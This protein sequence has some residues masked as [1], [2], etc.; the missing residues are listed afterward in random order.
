MAATSGPGS[1]PPL[2]QIA[3]AN[4]EALRIAWVWEA[5]DNHRYARRRAK[6]PDGFKATPLMVGG[7]LIVRTAFSAVAALDPLTGETLWTFDPGT[8]D[9]PRPPMFGFSTRGLAYHQ[10]EDGGRILLLTSD[11]WL[12]A[13]SPQTG[14]PLTD[15]GKAGRVDLT[16]GLR[17]P[18]LRSASSWNYAPA[19]CGDVVVV[20]NQTSDT[21]HISSFRRGGREWQDNVP[22]G[23]VRGFDV[24][25]GRRL[26]A[27]KT[28]P[29]AGEFGN[30][31]WGDGS[32][33]WMG[34]T[35]VW[36]M[37][38][39]DPEL[40]LVYLRS[41]R[42]PATSTAVCDRGTI[43]S[44]PPWLPW[45]RRPAP[46]PGTSRRCITTSGTTI[47]Q[48]RRWWPIWLSTARR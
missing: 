18:I 48:R 2:D 27:F 14:K 41:P 28:V 47:C 32:W 45:T 24:R 9:G 25:T 37:M 19:I 43:C 11:G 16:V 7:R 21:S 22:L 44:A 39:C 13:L 40:G 8:G 38:S 23:D 33:R 15:F 31:T 29:Q 3:P 26:W 30:E 46:A 6:T 17:R 35:N 1:T 12:M 5:F 34:N 10:D 4:L 42:P 36:S 20:G